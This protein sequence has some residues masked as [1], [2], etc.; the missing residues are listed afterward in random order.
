MVVS[1]RACT[2]N[3]WRPGLRPETLPVTVVGPNNRSNKQ[4]EHGED[5][6][7]IEYKILDQRICNGLPS[8]SWVKKMVPLTPSLLPSTATAFT[9]VYVICKQLHK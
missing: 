7:S 6:N 1:P 3:P 2:W 5:D 9:I 8:P 4:S